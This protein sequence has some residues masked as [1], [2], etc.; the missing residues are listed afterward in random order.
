[1]RGLWADEKID[2]FN[3]KKTNIPYRILKIF[4]NKIIKKAD[5]VLTLTNDSI[6][7]LNVR[8]ITKLDKFKKISTY[9]NTDLFKNTLL[10]ENNNITFAYVGSAFKAYDIEKVIYLIS[11]LIVIKDNIRLYIYSNDEVDKII[12]I[13]NKYKINKKYYEIRYVSHECLINELSYCDLGIFYLKNNYSIKASFP[14][15]IGE[16]L[17]MNIPI[18][19]NSFNQDINNIITNNEIGLINNFENQDFNLLY[20]KIIN[21]IEFNKKNNSCRDYALNNLSLNKGI[22]EYRKIYNETLDDI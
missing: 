19:C 12:S 5:K 2:R 13:L 10:K 6:D 1:M 7:I 8:Y 4:E 20:N 9:V 15:K 16:F 3:W 11:N 22:H 21:L 14:T 18:I 17:S